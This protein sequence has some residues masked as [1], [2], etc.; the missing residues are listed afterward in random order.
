[1]NIRRAK[2]YTHYSPKKARKSVQPGSYHDKIVNEI[3][4]KYSKD[5][6]NEM[7]QEQLAAE[8]LEMQ[9]RGSNS[10]RNGV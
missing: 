7:S 9:G 4:S 10:K 2:T 8:I 1:M 6:I 3:K 5:A